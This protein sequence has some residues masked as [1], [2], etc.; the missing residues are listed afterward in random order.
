VKTIAIEEHY[1]HPGIKQAIERRN[2]SLVKDFAGDGVLAE[3]F[4]KLDDVGEGRLRDMDEASIDVQVLSHT[5][6]AT[7]GLSPS[8]AIPL[9]RD[10]N[11]SLAKAIA[12][13]PERFAGFAT[14]PTPAPDAAADELERTV[15]VLGFKGALVNG[16]TGGRFLDDPIL[17]PILERASSLAV[18]LYLHPAP[19]PAPVRDAYYAGLAPSL[20]QHLAAGGWGWHVETGLHALRLILAGIFDRFPTLQVILG[21]MGEMIP[22]FLGRIDYALSP[23]ATHLQ[24]RVADYVLQNFSITTSGLFTVP[25]LLLVLQTMGADRVLFSVDY[26]YSLNTE[27]RALLDAAPISATEKENISHA[28]AERLLKLPVK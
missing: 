14:L 25:P 8:E 21:H 27:G 7:E 4:R 22:F 20:S 11:D 19:P 23:L 9:A 28:N 13:H 2:P 24:R 3:R 6:P 18:P 12:A 10:A 17:L 26:P 1:R 16:T 15:R 5:F